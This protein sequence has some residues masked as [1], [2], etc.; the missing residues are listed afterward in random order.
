[1]TK[2]HTSTKLIHT[3]I[4]ATIFIGL[5]LIILKITHQINWNWLWVTA[6]L[7]IG[8]GVI[9]S[10]SMLIVSITVGIVLATKILDTEDK[11]K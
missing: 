11:K 5:A 8:G 7:W 4:N 9:I 2:Q 10:L 3:I 1:M 6:P